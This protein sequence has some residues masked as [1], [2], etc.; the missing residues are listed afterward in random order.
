MRRGGE[1]QGIVLFAHGSRD[2]RWAR[3]FEQIALHVRKRLPST[4]VVLAYLES[5]RPSLEEALAALA[6]SKVNEIRVVPVFLGQGGHVRED[7]PKIVAA[8]RAAH[9]QVRI[10]LEEPIGERPRVIEA[11]AEAISRPS[12]RSSP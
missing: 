1:K 6:A 3:P 5:A 2:P 7:L 10:S 9:P 12:D 11:I 8:E 4:E